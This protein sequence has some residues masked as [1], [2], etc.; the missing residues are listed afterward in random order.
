MVPT[1]ALLL[2]QVTATPGISSPFSSNAI[3]ENRSVS[4]IASVAV[5][6][7]TVMVV[8]SGSTGSSSVTVTVAAP[9][10]SPADAVTVVVPPTRAVKR[11]CSSMLPTVVLLLAQV[12]ATPDISSPF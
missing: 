1:V 7:L 10:M 8:S 12:T 3:A 4:L 9:E 11:P 5:D 2:A 6:G